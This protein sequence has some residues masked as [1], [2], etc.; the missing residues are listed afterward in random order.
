[1]VVCVIVIAFFP[2]SDFSLPS[3]SGNVN[4]N[5]RLFNEYFLRKRKY[6]TTGENSFATETPEDFWRRLIEIEKECSFE[7]I[8]AEELISKFLTAIT[9]EKRQENL[10]KEE[11]PALKKTIEMIKQITYEKKNSKNTIPKAYQ[12]VMNKSKNQSKEWIDLQQD[13]R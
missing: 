8:T 4:S 1:M 11:K 6:I 9:D 13:Q 5:W 12:T 10:L 2:F 3:F 7:S